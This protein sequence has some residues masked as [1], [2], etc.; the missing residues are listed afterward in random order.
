M[1]ILLIVLIKTLYTLSEHLTFDLHKGDYS[2]TDSHTR[3]LETFTPLYG[4]TSSL[5]Y[6][7]I[8]LYIG[9]AQKRQ[10]LIIDTGSM[11]TTVP[12]KPLCEQCGQHLNS[13]YDL[14]GIFFVIIR[15]R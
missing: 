9:K 13:Y 2:G 8:N 11:V 7:Y 3:M 12:C 10:S 15:F 14:T 5:N 4:N 1:K 6:Y